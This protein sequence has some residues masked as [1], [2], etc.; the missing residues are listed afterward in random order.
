MT[1][2]LRLR[3]YSSLSRACC[4]RGVV[5][6]CTSEP[7]RERCFLAAGFVAGIT[8]QR[9]DCGVIALVVKGVDNGNGH[10]ANCVCDFHIHKAFLVGMQ[11]AMPV[12]CR[13]PISEQERDRVEC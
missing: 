4:S 11:A 12:R 8:V 5:S 10:R 9:L 3:S 1:V 7:K 13:V 2:K 6:T